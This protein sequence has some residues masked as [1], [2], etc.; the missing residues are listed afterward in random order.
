MKRVTSL[1][2][3]ISTRFSTKPSKRSNGVRLLPRSS[4][5]LWPVSRVSLGL[6]WRPTLRQLPCFIM[7]RRCGRRLPC[8]I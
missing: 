8:Q 2:Y 7:S 6:V 4:T 3:S 1:V 5:A